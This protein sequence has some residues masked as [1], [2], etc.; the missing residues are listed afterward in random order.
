MRR[1]RTGTSECRLPGVVLASVV[2]LSCMACS[3]KVPVHLS[4]LAVRLCPPV[5][6]SSGQQ[7][8]AVAIEAGRMKDAFDLRVRVAELVSAAHPR[9]CAYLQ[10]AS[11]HPD[12]SRVKN[13][14][15]DRGRLVVGL[16][17]RPPVLT[18][19]LHAI[20][21]PTDKP[22]ARN[23]FLPAVRGVIG[24]REVVG[25]RV[26]QASASNRVVTY[27]LRQTASRQWC[28]LTTRDPGSDAVLVLDRRVIG[29]TKVVR[30]LCGGTLRLPSPFHP[31][32]A[33]PQILRS[34]LKDGP[35]PFAWR[36]VSLMPSPCARQSRP[37]RPRLTGLR[38][39]LCMFG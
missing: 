16:V 6:A 38:R 19:R 15:S 20:R 1:A 14:L 5:T 10:V 17:L 27:S 24:W 9:P 7:R 22:T 2:C 28:R 18:G 37:K 11:S 13:V 25:P 3:Q 33:T 35:L 8:S 4:R 32:T 34:Y 21:F 30:P 31:G 36:S 23:R 39:L 26:Q 29:S 12:L